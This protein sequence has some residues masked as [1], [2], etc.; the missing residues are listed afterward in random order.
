MFFTRPPTTATYTLS[1]HDAL[2]ISALQAVDTL[3][4]DQS[5][6]GD[7]GRHTLRLGLF[8]LAQ[9]IKGGKA[10]GISLIQDR[11]QGSGFSSH[12]LDSQLLGLAFL[13][14]EKGQH[15][16]LGPALPMG[17]YQV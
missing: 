4:Q 3:T 14:I 10:F 7:F 8:H 9:A 6:P 2:P 11:S 5:G 1:L 17:L 16:A 12:N 15:S 13:R